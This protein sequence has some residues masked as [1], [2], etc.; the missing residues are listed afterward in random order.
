MSNYD[1]EV[2][3][4]TLIETNTEVQNQYTTINKK[5]LKSNIID[6]KGGNLATAIKGLSTQALSVNFPNADVE[7]Y[8]M[9]V[10]ELTKRLEQF[11]NYHE[12]NEFFDISKAI[13][14][15]KAERN[16]AWM[17]WRDK[18][19]RWTAGITAA[20]LMYSTFVYLSEKV[21]F[22]KVPVHDLVTAKTK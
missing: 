21:D 4:K 7:S 13:E 10:N 22:I 1:A 5:L 2:G 17:L 19:I 6:E 14:H 9:K 3:Y 12:K 8:L 15:R 11:S 20:V 18:L 16:D